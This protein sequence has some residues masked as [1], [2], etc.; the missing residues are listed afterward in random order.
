M[1]NLRLLLRIHIKSDLLNSLSFFPHLSFF[2]IVN[3]ESQINMGLEKEV[4]H[5][6]IKLPF[7]RPADFIEPPPVSDRR[8]P[9]CVPSKLISVCFQVVWTDEMEQQLWKYM[10]QKHTDCK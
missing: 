6:V 1:F 7:K 3:T 2:R 9:S 4:M 8:N 10:N 5:V